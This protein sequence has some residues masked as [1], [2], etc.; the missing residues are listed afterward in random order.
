M[1]YFRGCVVRDKL[2]QIAGATER[3]LNKAHIDYQTLDYEGCC[4]S[5]LLRCGFKE[6]ALEVMKKNLENL[7]G[8][9]IL[10]SCAGCYN[11]L[12][13]DYKELLQVELDVVHSTELFKELMEKKILKPE[14]TGLKVTYHDP[15]HLGRHCGEYEAPR[16]VL[17][18]TTCLL[19]MENIKA[20]SS[21]CGAGGGVKSAYPDTALKVAQK[22]LKEATD[23]GAEVLVTCCSFCILNLSSASEMSNNDQ[24][25]KLI[26]MDLS[27][28]LLKGL[29]NE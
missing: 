8:N 1:I 29:N 26:I 9:K 16:I 20:H 17:D 11:T 25:D 27:Q 21:C 28:A 14:K 18:R 24:E 15:C 3:V 7:K 12:K 22:R 2:P 6:E 4:G 5:F 10:V 13:N 23:T 19:E